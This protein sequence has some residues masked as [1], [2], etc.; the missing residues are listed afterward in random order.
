MCIASGCRIDRRALALF[1][2]RAAPQ[3]TGRTPMLRN[4]LVVDDNAMDRSILRGILQSKYDVLEAVDGREAL[5]ILDKRFDVISAVLLDLQMPVMDGYAVL[6]AVRSNALLNFLPIIAVTSDTDE[7]TQKLVLSHGANAFVKKPLNPELLLQLLSNTVSMCEMSAMHNAMYRDSL[8]GL[9]S[10]DS[11]LFEAERMIRQEKPGYYV[12][13]CFDIESF[14]VINEQYGVKTGDRVLKYVADCIS[15]CADEIGGICCRFVADKFAMLLPSSY[16]DSEKAKA[17]YETAIHPS[18]LNRT[19]RIRIGHYLVNDPAVPVNTMFD[20]ATMAERAVKD[21]YDTHCVVYDDEMRKNLLHEQQVVSDM[22]SALQDGEFEAWLQPQYNH[23]TGA[24]V[25]AE[26]LV[27]WRSTRAGRLLSPH[28]FIPIFERNGFIYEVDKFVWE[29]VC[30]ILHRR[31]AEGKKNIPISVNIARP[32]LYHEDFLDVIV[33]LVKK[34]EISPELLPLEITESAFYNSPHQIIAVVKAL[35]RYGFTVEIDD[36]GSGYSSLNTLKDVPAQV[37]K[38][39]MYFLKDIKHS[40]RGGSIV[41]SMLRMSKWLEMSV[42]AEGVETKEQA[43]YLKSLGCN[44]LQG[45]YYAKAMALE[46][47]EKLLDAGTLERAQSSAEFVENFDNMMFWD[48]ASLETMVFNHFSG[49]AF[50]FEYHNERY[51]M[52]RIND[53]FAKTFRSPYTNEE[54]LK[55]EPFSILDSTERREVLGTVQRAYQSGKAETCD[56]Y[57]M[58][59]CAP[60]HGEYVRFTVRR[61]AACNDRI[62]FYGYVDNITEQHIAELKEINASRRLSTIINNISGAVSAAVIRNDIPHLLLAN[63][64]FY[65]V[66]GYSKDEYDTGIINPHDQIL[67]EDIEKYHQAM[68]AARATGSPYSLVYRI[69]IR[70]GSIRW[71]QANITYITLPQVD[72]PVELSVIGD[73]T[74]FIESRNRERAAKEEEERVSSQMCAIMQNV[75]GGVS[76]TKYNERGEVVFS[77]TNDRFF[78]MFGYTKAEAE[79]SGIHMMSL[80]LPEDMPKVTDA[81]AGLTHHSYES[82][83]VDYRCRKKDGSIINVRCNASRA[84]IKGIGDDVIVSVAM[85]VTEQY[86]LQR[87]EQETSD[88]LKSILAHVNCGITAVVLNEDTPDFLFANNKYYEILGYTREYFKR[89]IKSPMDTVFQADRA[90]VRGQVIEASETQDGR[91]IIFRAV[92]ADGR[93]IWMK[94]SIGI[95]NLFGLDRPVQ[96]SVFSDITKEHELEET[97]RQTAE[98]LQTVM[99]SMNSGVCA[100]TMQNGVPVFLFAN[101][102]YYSML[103]YTRETFEATH[104]QVFSIIHPDD[105]ER[106]A[107]EFRRSFMSMEPYTIE[108]RIVHP[109]GSIRWLQSKVTLMHLIGVPDAVQFAVAD[110]ITSLHEAR[111]RERRITEQLNAIITNVDCGIFATVVR[112]GQLE[113]LFSNDRFYELL[114][115]PQE[116]LQASMSN[117]LEFVHPDDRE[118]VVKAMMT[119]KANGDRAQ[120]EYR[121]NRTDGQAT[122][123]RVHVS[124]TH[125][126]GIE[127]PVELAIAVDVTAEKEAAGQLKLLNTIA[128][129]LLTQT[130]AKAGIGSILRQLMLHFKGRRAYIFELSE[131]LKSVSNTF[132]VC[133]QG[134]PSKLQSLQNIPMAQLPYWKSAFGGRSHFYISNAQTAD[135]SRAEDLAFLQTQGLTSLAAALL[136]REGRCLGIIGIENPAAEPEWADRLAALGDYISVMLT[137]RDLTEKLEQETAAINGVMNGIPGGFIRME[138]LPDKTLKP[139]YISDGFRRLVAMNGAQAA[140]FYRKDAANGVYAEDL[141]AAKEMVERLLSG[142]AISSERIRLLRGDGSFVWVTVSGK[143]QKSDSG[144]VFLNSYYSDAT[145]QMQ[146]EEQRFELLDNLPCG[147][148]LYDFDGERLTAIHLNARYWELVG[149]SPCTL[150]KTVKDSNIYPDDRRLVQQELAAAIHQKRNF[151][152][153][154][155]I[156]CGSDKYRPFHIEGRLIPREN[157]HYAV[158]ASYAPYEEGKMSVQA[159][160]PIALSTMMDTSSDLTFIKG[161]DQRY[162]ACSKSGAA[163]SGLADAREI[164]GKTDYELYSKEQAEQYI[165]SDRQ[166]METG[167]PV[168]DCDE[169]VTR[170]DGTIFCNTFSKY[171]LRDEAGRIIGTYCTCHDSE[172]VRMAVFELNTLLNVIP[173]GIFKYAADTKQFAYI[174]LSLITSLGYTRES[175]EEKFH[176]SFHEMVYVEDRDRVEACILEQEVNGQVGAQEYRI[177]AADGRLVWFRNEGRRV[178]DQNGKDWHYVVVQN[179]TEM[180]EAARIERQLTAENNTLFGNSTAWIFSCRNDDGWTLLKTNRMLEA[181][182]GYTEDELH[183]LLC[184]ETQRVIADTDVAMVRENIAHNSSPDNHAAFE[185]TLLKKDGSLNHVGVNLLLSQDSDGEEVLYVTCVDYNP[186]YH[187]NEEM[188][189]SKKELEMLYNFV[190]GGVFLCDTSPEW[191]LLRANDGFFRMTGISR[192]ELAEQYDNALA[193]MIPPECVAPVMQNTAKQLRHGRK[194][195]NTVPIMVNGELHWHEIDSQYIVMEDGSHALYCVSV[196]VT[197]TMRIQQALE[198]ET[199]TIRQLYQGLPCGVSQ[200]RFL[201]DGRFEF[202]FLNPAGYQLYGFPENMALED[203]NALEFLQSDR[204]LLPKKAMLRDSTSSDDTQHIYEIRQITGVHRWVMCSISVVETVDKNTI[205]QT[206]FTDVT[207]QHLDEQQKAYNS[208]LKT[209]LIAEKKANRA[210]SEFL[211]RVSHEIRTPMNAIMG[212]NEVQLQEIG[213]AKLQADCIRKSQQ[214]AKYLL[215][216]MNDILDMSEF[217]SEHVELSKEPLSLKELLETVVGMVQPQMES[218]GILFSYRQ[219]GAFASSYLGDAGRIEQILMHLLSNAIKFTD[220]GGEIRFTAAQQSIQDDAATVRFTV[221][222]TGVGIDPDFLPR[223]FQ[224]FAREHEGKTNR[225]SGS[226]L[227]LSISKALARMMGGDITVQ[228]TQGKGSVFTVTIRL[229]IDKKQCRQASAS[230]D[231]DI[232]FDGKRILICEDQPINVMVARKLLEKRGAVVDVAEN[233]KLGTEKF[234]FSKDREYDAILM[235]IRMPVMDGLEATRA[236]R[237]LDRADAKTIPILAMTANT[238]PADKQSALDAG[239]NAHLA[240]PIAPKLLYDTLAEHLHL[241]HE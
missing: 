108:F 112:D 224:P 198:R 34:Y 200:C 236:I 25:G 148:G 197:N 154:V 228:S 64:Y 181:Y 215:S 122:W 124:R 92:R 241:K 171:P 125:F 72:G 132:E 138:V 136:L 54:I 187:A 6:D 221:G 167:E 147:A 227:G 1:S 33:G 121:V 70:D 60:G 131:D 155:R 15:D 206:I 96:L 177:E 149:R 79:L 80:I 188:R 222:D 10:R 129:N 13:S 99:E 86:D 58:R 3:K 94:T 235:D 201:P 74:E 151:S 29:Q 43:D 68:R 88:K 182:T 193:R 104:P 117:S 191:R 192:E 8:T 63:N 217:K 46:D 2:F 48:P 81:L 183:T 212:L 163:F 152:V 30:Q 87:K 32:D 186:I 12:L 47:F 216:L 202:V 137:R 165:E 16:I 50:I 176:N 166:V 45:Y 142:A 62:L 51:E 97:S 127:E 107:D 199:A 233:G 61:I 159:L 205:Y 110:D 239:M 17:L 119:A 21:R 158:Y 240:K 116:S 195:T 78:E 14:T 231:G 101:S 175:F 168:I 128:G 73:I 89:V 9:Y 156:L 41:E 67:R 118:K 23:S 115:R 91:D 100:T 109:D 141:P 24:I 162:I 173:S 146:A 172:T 164:A 226:G 103:G 190:P 185:A 169:I 95:V 113:L 31:S 232:R 238:Y 126:S 150:T 53:E 204:F 210:K 59:Y 237:A 179:I 139:L 130:D 77:Y 140:K 44:Y 123:L 42:I 134:V 85:D 133:A 203:V 18:G 7:E 214:S 57:S 225:F 211:A 49:G 19:L 184:G 4:V 83:V 40:Q 71:L 20:C 105:R 194:V 66:F 82:A 160:L 153:N 52:L 75:S 11:F 180:K 223:L 170:K 90:Y 28:E 208:K 144:K 65:Q 84:K 230:S 219:V 135:G 220:E 157:G 120:I 213:N 145:A 37:L 161:A 207:Q 106:V 55:L 143:I 174:N 209:E 196:D 218:K 229:E 26:A 98:R 69:R 56:V 178:T 36:F 39:D 102:R 114:G 189:R 38:L 22:V 35:Q 93:V 111:E 234:A 76:A 27:R 5:K